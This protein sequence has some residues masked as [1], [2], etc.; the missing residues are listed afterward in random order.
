L[1]GEKDDFIKLGEIS[2]EILYA[3]S[4][5]SSPAVLTLHKRATKMSG[6]A[7]REENQKIYVEAKLENV[8]P[9][10]FLPIDHRY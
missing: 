2:Q 10:H 3:W 7:Y 5:S 9:R 6:S 1:R 8:H 4:L